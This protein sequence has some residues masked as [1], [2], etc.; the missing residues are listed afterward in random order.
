MHLSSVERGLML[1]AIILGMERI[2]KEQTFPSHTTGIVYPKEAAAAAFGEKLD[3]IFRLPSDDIENG[4]PNIPCPN[5]VSSKQ[6]G[7]EILRLNMIWKIKSPIWYYRGIIL[8]ERGLCPLNGLH[9]I[10][11]LES[12]S[13]LGESTHTQFGDLGCKTSAAYQEFQKTE[14]SSSTKEKL[15]FGEEAIHSYTLYLNDINHGEIESVPAPVIAINY[16]R[17][18]K[19]STLRDVVTIIRSNESHHKDVNHFTSPQE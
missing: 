13:E 14:G 8:V 2:F 19:E 10:T 4:L 7:E 6:L 1:S 12:D 5:E 3:D 9:N 11:H 17:L 15:K 16:W 18:P